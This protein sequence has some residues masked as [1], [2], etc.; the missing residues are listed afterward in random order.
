LSAVFCDTSVLLRAYL[1]DEEDHEALAHMVFEGDEPIVASELARTELAAG[2]SR[3]R[4][5]GRLAEDK[6]RELLR[7]FDLDVS[8]DGPIV[9]LALEPTPTLERARDL[10]LA[11]DIGTLD[12]IHLAAAERLSA[13]DEDVVFCSRDARQLEAARAVGFGLR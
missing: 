2:L 5:S 6:V 8:A 9:L 1:A 7:A 13:N 12:A 4:R 3:A 11:Y 10:V